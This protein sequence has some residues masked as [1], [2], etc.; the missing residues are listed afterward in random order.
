MID[1]TCSS[2]AG[3]PMGANYD[4]YRLNMPSEKSWWDKVQSWL[5]QRKICS[6]NNHQWSHGSF[7]VICESVINKQ[8]QIGYCCKCG[9]VRLLFCS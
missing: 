6:S 4:E 8:A 3:L 9:I 7:S 2:V 1:T 5:H